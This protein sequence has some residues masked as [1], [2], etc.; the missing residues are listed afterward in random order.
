MAHLSLA[1]CAIVEVEGGAFERRLVHVRRPILPC[2]SLCIH[3][4]SG[5]ERAA[6]KPNKETHLQPVLGMVEESLFRTFFSSF[7]ALDVKC[8]F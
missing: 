1:G 3:L 6:F 8:S 2:P 4:Q 7:E 5:E